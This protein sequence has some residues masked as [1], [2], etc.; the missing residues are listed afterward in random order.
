M[1][2]SIMPT[3]PLHTQLT[4]DKHRFKLI[5][6]ELIQTF[7]LSWTGEKLVWSQGSK[8]RYC[9]IPICILVYDWII[10]QGHCGS[11]Y[12]FSAVGAIEGA[13]SLRYGNLV[14]VSA[15]NIIDCSGV[16]SHSYMH[17]TCTAIVCYITGRFGNRGC[18]GGN[19]KNSFRYVISNKGINSA[20]YYP[21]RA[22]VR[23]AGVRA[24]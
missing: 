19:M 8:N 14:N 3:S 9:I 18:N 24:Y 12:A 4:V 21:Y 7:H 6:W 13:W 23:L 22:R 5:C 1:R 16:W 11:S 10:M 17:F 20:T 15:Q 2:S